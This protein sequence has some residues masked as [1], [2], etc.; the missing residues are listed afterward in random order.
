MSMPIVASS[1]LCAICG[2]P[3]ANQFLGSFENTN[4]RKMTEE[5]NSHEDLI[6][7]G[8]PRLLG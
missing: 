1:R 5:T 8:A 4:G 3:L 6:A 2:T 7:D